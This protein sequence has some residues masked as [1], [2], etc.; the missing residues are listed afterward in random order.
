MNKFQ[1]NRNVFGQ[2]LTVFFFF[3]FVQ[4]SNDKNVGIKLGRRPKVDSDVFQQGYY[5]PEDMEMLH[6][7]GQQ[8]SWPGADHLGAHYPAVFKSE[9]TATDIESHGE[10]PVMNYSLK[11]EAYTT[12][13]STM[14]CITHIMPAT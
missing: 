2:L 3:P 14:A 12:C 7:H 4:Y 5:H 10:Q 6:S 8:Y 9:P 1:T 11:R 13:D